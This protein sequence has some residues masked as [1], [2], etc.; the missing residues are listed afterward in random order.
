M[1]IDPQ[2]TAPPTGGFDSPSP[3]TPTSVDIA[4]ATTQSG[5]IKAPIPGASGLRHVQAE[6]PVSQDDPTSTRRG[7]RA[8]ARA[9]RPVRT[10]R[11]REAAPQ[12]LA[13]QTPFE[14]DREGVLG[15]RAAAAVSA[16]AVAQV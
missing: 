4:S 15:T 16:G 6:G 13:E 7:G 8:P 12:A 2:G 9:G 11:L 1:F 10:L 3:S 5:A 14:D